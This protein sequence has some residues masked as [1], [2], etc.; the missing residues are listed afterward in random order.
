MSPDE[1]HHKKVA[2]RI[3]H[4][5]TTSIPLVSVP[6]LPVF[7]PQFLVVE[8]FLYVQSYDFNYRALNK[9]EFDKDDY[10][11]LSALLFIP[12]VFGC[13]AF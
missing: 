1:N 8:N 3:Y 4:R 7:W 5:N 9:L 11:I 10:I 13:Y 2:S 6:L 12:C